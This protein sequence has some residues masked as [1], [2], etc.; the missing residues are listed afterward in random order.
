MRQTPGISLRGKER[1]WQSKAA[2]GL[3]MLLR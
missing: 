3:E 1:K 2:K